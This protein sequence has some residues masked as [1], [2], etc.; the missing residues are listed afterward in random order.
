[1]AITGADLFEALWNRKVNA[2]YSQQYSSTQQSALLNEALIKVLED[3]YRM[4][5]QIILLTKVRALV[6]TEN[7]ETTTNNSIDLFT[8]I[9][10]FNHLMAVKLCD[11]G[12]T[13]LHYIN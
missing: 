5:Y 4:G 8:L 6:S 7:V 1:M 12:Y 2:V 11:R 3:I 9:P 13:I 10:D